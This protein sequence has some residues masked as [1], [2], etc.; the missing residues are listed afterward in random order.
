[1]LVAPYGTS[2]IAIHYKDASTGVDFGALRG[3]FEVS[4]PCERLLL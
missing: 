4:K 2:L 1:M 3:I